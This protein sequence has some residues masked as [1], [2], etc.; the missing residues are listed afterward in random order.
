MSKTK[1]DISFSV[2]IDD[3]L[4]RALGDDTLPTETLINRVQGMVRREV[5]AYDGV[6]FDPAS[7]QV[8]LSIPYADAVGEPKFQEPAADESDDDYEDDDYED[9]EDDEEPA[10]AHAA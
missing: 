8:T 7:V 3:D 10:A 2:Q 1:A 4:L 5:Y 6:T 9:D